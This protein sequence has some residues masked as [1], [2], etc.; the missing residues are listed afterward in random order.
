M[1]LHLSVVFFNADLGGNE[2]TVQELEV[3]TWTWVYEHIEEF[4]ASE[5]P[6]ECRLYDLGHRF[7]DIWRLEALAQ[8]AVFADLEAADRQTVKQL[9]GGWKTAHPRAD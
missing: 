1:L 2:A 5:V 9:N 3:N 8:R 7:A 4:V 6:I